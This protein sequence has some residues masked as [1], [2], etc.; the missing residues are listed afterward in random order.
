MKRALNTRAVAR[1][2]TP[3]EPTDNVLIAYAR[4]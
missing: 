1:G 2:L 4:I 3:T